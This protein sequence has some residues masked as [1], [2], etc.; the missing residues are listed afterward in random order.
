MRGLEVVVVLRVDP[1]AAEALGTALPASVHPVAEGVERVH[2]YTEWAS[3]VAFVAVQP[4]FGFASRE[5]EAS[6]QRHD[7]PWQQD[8][9][10][11][12]LA[13]EGAQQLEVGLVALE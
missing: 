2:M 12:T 6:E 5:G 11:N 10:Q 3:C 9:P 1:D 13:S 7:E 4:A 8:V